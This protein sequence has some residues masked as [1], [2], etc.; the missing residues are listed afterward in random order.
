MFNRTE[1]VYNDILLDL[2]VGD[3]HVHYTVTL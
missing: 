2:I 3:D 1:F